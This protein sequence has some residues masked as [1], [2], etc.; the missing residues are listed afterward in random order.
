MIEVLGADDDESEGSWSRP[1]RGSTNLF[2]R[3][4]DR[5]PSLEWIFIWH[6]WTVLV[7]ET[8]AMLAGAYYLIRGFPDL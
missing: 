6:P 7:H 4:P 1:W 8:G 2:K 3:D 5:S